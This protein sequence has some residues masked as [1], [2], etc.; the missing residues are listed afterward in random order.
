MSLKSYEG[1]KAGRSF[2]TWMPNSEVSLALQSV[3]YKAIAVS[4]LMMSHNI[5]ELTG[6]VRLFL[7]SDHL[8]SNSHSRGA[9]PF[10]AKG[11]GVSLSVHSRTKHKMMS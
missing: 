3:F 6:L 2:C 7:H 5:I 9:Q 8:Y 4:L 11:R 10:W 1:G